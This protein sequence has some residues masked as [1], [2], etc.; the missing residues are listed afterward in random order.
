MRSRPVLAALLGSLTLLSAACSATVNVQPQ[1]PTTSAATAQTQSAETLTVADLANAP[2]PA[3]CEHPAGNLRDFSLPNVPSG[4]GG[5]SLVHEASQG[6]PTPLTVDLDGDGRQEI[7][8]VYQCNAGGVAWPDQVLVYGPGPTLKGWLALG[9]ISRTEHAEVQAWRLTANKVYVDWISYNGG[10][11]ADWASHSNY[12]SFDGSIPAASGGDG[13]LSLAE[14]APRTVP[15]VKV[16]GT[17]TGVEPPASVQAY[18]DDLARGDDAHIIKECWTVS[19]S[20]IRAQLASREEI[21]KALSG[22]GG[23]TESGLSWKSGELDVF[24]T[25]SE[26]GSSYACPTIAGSFFTAADGRL[27]LAR[28]DGRLNTTPYQ[29][30]DTEDRYPLL[31]SP[32]QYGTQGL[33]SA[34][35][36][37]G[38]GTERSRTPS[39]VKQA[40]A[41]MARHV[42]VVTPGPSPDTYS[43]RAADGSSGSTRVVIGSLNSRMCLLGTAAEG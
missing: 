38:S 3:S 21:L 5:G 9:D 41:R 15:T 25:S 28:L 22:P 8:A 23:G 42:L 1:S 11:G 14:V 24:F 43:L 36:A 7:L 30:S 31:C 19:Q 6:A 12:L 26:V 16:A 17:S 37:E 20:T 4:D 29:P 18:A 27:L 13:T 39:E 32:E 33:Q 10:I 2:V 34:V 35:A 40:V